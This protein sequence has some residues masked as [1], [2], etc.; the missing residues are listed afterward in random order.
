[1]LPILS[2]SGQTDRLQKGDSR[3]GEAA[4]LCLEHVANGAARTDKRIGAKEA[5]E[6]S[7]DEQRLDVLRRRADGIPYSEQNV[8]YDKA[9]PSSEDF[10]CRRPEKRTGRK[11]KDE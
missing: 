1:M 5:G 11:H 4:L 3:H 6:Q 2:R 10:A 7:K 8:G 9:R